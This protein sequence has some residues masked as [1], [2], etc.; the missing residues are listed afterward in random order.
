[1]FFTPVKKFFL[2]NGEGW[3]H[4][5]KQGELYPNSI[6]KSYSFGDKVVTIDQK[7]VHL[8]IYWIKT[9]NPTDI[10]EVI[11]ALLLTSRSGEE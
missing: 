2:K 10:H 1:M 6:L 7:I 3:L 11:K 8:G 5:F 9:I 4:T